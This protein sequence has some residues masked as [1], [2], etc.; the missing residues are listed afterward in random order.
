[1]PLTRK[2]AYGIVGIAVIALLWTA[3]I[4][5]L[6]GVVVIVLVVALVVILNARLR[7]RRPAEGP[8]D[9]NEVR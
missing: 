2:N 6:G 9:G 1:V 5:V 7:R 4:G 8:S 3:I